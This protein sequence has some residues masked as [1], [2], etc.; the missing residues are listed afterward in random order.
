MSAHPFSSKH[1]HC[2]RISLVNRL[3]L[4]ATWDTQ[5]P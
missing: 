1:G 5:V 2:T 3:T 4:D